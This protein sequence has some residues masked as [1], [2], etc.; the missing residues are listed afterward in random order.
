MLHELAETI[1]QRAL[2][3][4]LSDL[5]IEPE[6]LRDCFQ[7]L[8]FRRHDVAVFHLLEA[9][10]ISFD[11]KRPMRFLDMEGRPR[12]LRRTERYRRPLPSAVR[13]YLE[14]LRKVV[15]ESGVDYHRVMIED[16][17]EHVLGRFLAGRA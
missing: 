6:L 10:E 8:Q 7:H 2:I 4:I 11:F 17:Y 9:R 12:H 3:V 13:E 5:F 15:L 16:N 14:A 1:R